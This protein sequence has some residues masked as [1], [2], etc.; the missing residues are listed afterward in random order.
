[1]FSAKWYPR[2]MRK[3]LWNW[4]TE[5]I[6]VKGMC[7]LILH[8]INNFQILRTQ[9]KAWKLGNA[10]EDKPKEKTLGKFKF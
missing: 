3:N 8:C 9:S 6:L 5:G 1:M 7:G 2:N 4:S 10:R